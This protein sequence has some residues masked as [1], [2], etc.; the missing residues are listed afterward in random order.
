M[1]R[2][3]IEVPNIGQVVS[4]PGILKR[5]RPALPVL[6]AAFHL[7]RR[8]FAVSKNS[9]MAAAFALFKRR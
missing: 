6:L 4:G 2:L 7:S 5:M 3:K 8:R 1:S 9:V